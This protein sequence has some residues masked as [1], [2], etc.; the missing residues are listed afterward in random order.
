MIP[1]RP[2][3]VIP[4]LRGMSGNSAGRG[5]TI[6]VGDGFRMKKSQ[7]QTDIDALRRAKSKCDR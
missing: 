7:T 1:S 4:T 3:E 6:E 2:C 5:V